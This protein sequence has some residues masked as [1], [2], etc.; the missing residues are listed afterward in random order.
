MPEYR[1]PR[2]PRVRA[3]L[4]AGHGG[5]GAEILDQDTAVECSRLNFGSLLTEPAW[6]GHD[7]EGH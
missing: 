6:Q 4:P 7:I 5:L 2:Q 3:G 1:L